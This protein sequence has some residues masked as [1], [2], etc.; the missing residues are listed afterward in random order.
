LNIAF[1]ATHPEDGAIEVDVFA[2]GELG[3]KSGADF[4][5]G[6]NASVELH[7]AF[8]GLCDPAEEL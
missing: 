7:R 1:V 2:S 6:P 8:G 5:E 3:V 4:E